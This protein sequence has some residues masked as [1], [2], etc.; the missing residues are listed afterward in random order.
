MCYVLPFRTEVTM[1]TGWLLL[2]VVAVVSS[3]SVD[4]QTTSADEVCDQQKLCGMIR[5]MPTLLE[6]QQQLL[7]Q[8]QLLLQ[9]VEANTKRLGKSQFNILDMFCINFACSRNFRLHSLSA[10]FRYLALPKDMTPK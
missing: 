2:L 5:D 6:N 1:T 10:H 4:S 7:R 9:Q 8:Q 3:Q